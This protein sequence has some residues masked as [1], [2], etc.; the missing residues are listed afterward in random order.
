M[1]SKIRRSDEPVYWG[2]F[3]AGGMVVGM[4]LPA[5]LILMLLQGLGVNCFHYFNL[6]SHWW[7][8]LAIF[9]IIS[10]CLWHGL[11]RIYHS[12]HDQLMKPTPLHHY[13][14]YWGGLVLTVLTGVF[15]FGYYL[16]I[17]GFLNLSL[18]Q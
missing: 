13:V 11:H 7:G 2:L 1:S 15:V 12:L 3:G 17:N 16:I 18:Q 8:A 6:I 4:A 5:L 14:L 10:G 9:V